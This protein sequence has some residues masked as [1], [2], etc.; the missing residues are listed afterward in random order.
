M[1]NG[2]LAIMAWNDWNV[3]ELFKR[4]EA[5]ESGNV[6]KRS[7]FAENAD[8]YVERQS[9]WIAEH[10]LSVGDKV[11]VTR[12]AKDFEDGWMCLW[13]TDMNA[14]VGEILEIRAFEDGYGVELR[15]GN[16]GYPCLYPYFVLEVVK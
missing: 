5:L 7:S 6:V 12:A 2:E 11:K 15:R 13:D 9:E 8:E 10:K 16:H 4:V 1:A 14:C 3:L